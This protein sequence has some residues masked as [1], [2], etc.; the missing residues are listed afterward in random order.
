MISTKHKE[1]NQQ[2]ASNAWNICLN[3]MNRWL[4]KK[5]KGQEN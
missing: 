5:K 4:M 3:S 2:Q 1:N